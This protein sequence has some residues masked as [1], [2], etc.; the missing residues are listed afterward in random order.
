MAKVCSSLVIVYY[1]LFRNFEQPMMG[2]FRSVARV[3]RGHKNLMYT[4]VNIVHFN[5]KRTNAPAVESH[6][7]HSYS[8]V[9]LI[10]IMVH[11]IP[12]PHMEVL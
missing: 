5:E 9:S 4:G 2:L 3:S 10:C 6:H 8:L 1:L 12:L 11:S 7:M